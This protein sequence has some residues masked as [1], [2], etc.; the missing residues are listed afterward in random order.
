MKIREILSESVTFRADIH[1]S[2]EMFANV[3]SI[4]FR[5]SHAFERAYQP[6][7]FFAKFA[8]KMAEQRAWP[9]FDSDGDDYDQPTGT[10]NVYVKPEFY[11]SATSQA[12]IK[13]LKAA[14][15]SLEANGLEFG[16]LKFEGEKQSWDSPRSH[17]QPQS[18]DVRVIRVPVV[19]NDS[20][21]DS[22][23]VIEVNLS[24]DNARTILKILGLDDEDL[25]GSVAHSQIPEV[26]SKINSI[27]KSGQVSTHSRPAS[28][29]HGPAKLTRTQFGGEIQ[30]GATV[31]DMG[32]SRERISEILQRLKQS[33]QQAFELKRDFVY[34]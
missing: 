29:T 34:S 19:R 14:M 1:D 6:D 5:L 12:V 20:Q 18:D 8:A 30:R 9:R 31:H 15:A 25:T 3:L 32:L 13:Y 7:Q 26:I 2:A 21:R 23:K 28:T 22:K 17:V 4:S 10:I 11:N 24:N 27:L 33:M 16:E